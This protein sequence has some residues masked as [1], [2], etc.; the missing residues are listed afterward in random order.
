MLH[1]KAGMDLN[2]VVE[3]IDHVEDPRGVSKCTCDDP[4]APERT[5]PVHVDPYDACKF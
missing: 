4:S 2:D 3:V 1:F 5:C